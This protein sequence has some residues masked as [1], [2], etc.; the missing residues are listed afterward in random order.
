MLL[1]EK[2]VRLK[3]LKRETVP[4]EAKPEVDPAI[5]SS[6]VL[7]ASEFPPIAILLLFVIL[8]ASSA[9]L[10]PSGVVEKTILPGISAEPVVASVSNE[11]EAD[12]C[13]SAPSYPCALNLLK[14]P[15]EPIIVGEA[16]EPCA[17]LRLI[18]LTLP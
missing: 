9:E 2:L 16:K 6:N 10:L 11:I 15:P 4:P 8:I 1:L 5:T 17:L 13:Q 7:G 12:S 14:I 3:V 18:L